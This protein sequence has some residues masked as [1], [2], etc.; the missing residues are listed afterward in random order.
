MPERR[1]VVLMSK[2]GRERVCAEMKQ[3]QGWRSVVG[4]NQTLETWNID[5]VRV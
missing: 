3:T 2:R 4:V 1:S 5:Y